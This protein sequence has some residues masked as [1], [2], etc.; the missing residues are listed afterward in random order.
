MN[1]II[2]GSN[3]K[4]FVEELKIIYAMPPL[5][6]PFTNFFYQKFINIDRE[7]CLRSNH[8]VKSASV[9]PRLNRKQTVFLTRLKKSSVEIGHLEM[10]G[11]VNIQ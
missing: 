3:K 10:S 1:G 9:S 7:S 6:D 4:L 8:A 5:R 2:K 11:G